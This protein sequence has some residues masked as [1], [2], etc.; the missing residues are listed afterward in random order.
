MDGKHKVG[1]RPWRTPEEN[2]AWWGWTGF[3]GKTLWAPP[4]NY[5]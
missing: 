1:W 3:G 5:K 2:K 4:A